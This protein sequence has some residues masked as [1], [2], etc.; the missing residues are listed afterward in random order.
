MFAPGAGE[1]SSKPV[2]T[3]NWIRATGSSPFCFEA[4]MMSVWPGP[5]TWS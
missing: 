3:K 5:A 2:G 1:L 4:S